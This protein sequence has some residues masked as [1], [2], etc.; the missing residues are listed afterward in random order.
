MR[1]GQRMRATLVAALAAVLMVAAAPAV[2][3]RM[4]ALLGW[5]E[6][7]IRHAVEEYDREATRI[8]GIDP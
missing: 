1:T 7:G 3:A 5:T 4:G 2:A 8:F 6:A